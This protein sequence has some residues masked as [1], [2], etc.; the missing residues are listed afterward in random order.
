MANLKLALGF[1]PAT[2]KIEQAEIDLIKEFEKLEA[3][4][5]SEELK[6]FNE[7]DAIVN[8]AEFKSKKKEIE[9]LSFKSI[10]RES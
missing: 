9:G 7:L 3:F 1:I 10:R 5:D 2:S 4:T 6:K 8:S